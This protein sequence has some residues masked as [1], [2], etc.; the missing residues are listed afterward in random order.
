VHASVLFSRGSAKTTATTA[1]VTVRLSAKALR[2]LRSGHT[3]HVSGRFSFRPLA[4][5]APVTRAISDVL[6][7]P[8]KRKH[9]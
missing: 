3:L 4:G 2:G 8:K 9:R 6:R 1:R 5:G 7:A